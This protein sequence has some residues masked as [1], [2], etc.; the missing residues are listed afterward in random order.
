MDA[1]ADADCVITL[2][3]LA[4]LFHAVTR[5]GKMPAA[6]AAALAHDWMELFPVAVADGRTLRQAIAL[7]NEHGFGF[8]DAML[9]GTVLKGMTI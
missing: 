4:E 7:R 1:L 8:W 6:E 2:Q 3:A 9:A 5:K